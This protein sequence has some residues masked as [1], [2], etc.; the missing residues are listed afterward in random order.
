M[1][2]NNVGAREYLFALEAI[3]DENQHWY[4][5]LYPWTYG[6]DSRTERQ[7]KNIS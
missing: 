4:G 1:R 7:I 2:K 6:M 5:K 3:V